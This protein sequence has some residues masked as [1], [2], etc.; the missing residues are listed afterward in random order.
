MHLILLHPRAFLLR[1]RLP[2]PMA[3]D[4]Q[5]CRTLDTIRAKCAPRVT[6]AESTSRTGRC[7]LGAGE[8]RSRGSESYIGSIVT[9]GGDVVVIVAVMWAGRRGGCTR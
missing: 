7:E 8:G 5:T 3:P 9:M 4:L 2:F 6:V 1:E